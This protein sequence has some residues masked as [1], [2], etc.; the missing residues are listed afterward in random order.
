[1]VFQGQFFDLEVFLKGFYAFVF[2]CVIASGVYL[3]NDIRDAEKDRMHPVKK[4]RPI[5]AGKISV[6]FATAVAI[7]AFAGFIPLSFIVIGRHFG[8]ILCVYVLLQ[9]AYTLKLKDVIIVDALTISI[10]F[11]LRA[12]AGALAIPL[13]ISSWLVLAIIG[14]SLLLAFGKRRAERTLLVA[15][16]ISKESTRTIL[17]HYPENLLDSMISM[18]AS[19]SIITYS[20]FA[21]Q[22][23]SDETIKSTLTKFLPSI[24]AGP[25]LLMLTIP[26]VIYCVGRYLYII[27]E[28]KEGESPE[29]VL[30]SDKPFLFSV[31]LWTVVV[32]LITNIIPSL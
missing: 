24:L 18:S 4:N 9:I 20:L 14:V 31:V 26:I 32:L 3:I 13:S 12:F 11:I 28:K 27:Y 8:M 25:R 22:S 16:G 15:Q 7:I 6:H 5:A 21:F 17:K 2:F 1:I 23:S 10:G 30:L 29:R 19:F